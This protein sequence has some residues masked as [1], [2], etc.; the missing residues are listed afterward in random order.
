VNRFDYM[1]GVAEQLREQATAST[2]V[3]GRFESMGGVVEQLRD[4]AR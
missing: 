4:A 2:A 3:T 1:G